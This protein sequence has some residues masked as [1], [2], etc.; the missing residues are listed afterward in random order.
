Q[1]DVYNN[2]ARFITPSEVVGPMMP[3]DPTT[4]EMLRSTMDIRVDEELPV[5]PEPDETAR[6]FIVRTTRD[7]WRALIGE[8]VE[9]WSDAELVDNF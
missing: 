7:K 5:T 8:Q 2:F 4:E 3:W 6:S 9:E 1:V